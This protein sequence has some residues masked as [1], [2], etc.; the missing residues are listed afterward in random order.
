[1][2]KLYD[3]YRSSASFRV[4]IALNL[5]GLDYECIPIHLVNQGGEQ[6]AESYRKLNPQQLVPTLADGNKILTQSFAIIEYLN[7]VYPE[8]ALLPADYYT[9]SLIRSFA[10]SIVADLHPLNNLRV[11]NYLKNELHITDTQKEG[12]YQ[13]W[14]KL[15]LTALE[16]QL[17]AHQLSGQFCFGDQ[18][19]LADIC[20]VPQ[21][22]NA[23]RFN[24]DLSNYPTL[25]KID[26]H[27]QTLDAVIKA[28]PK[29]T[30]T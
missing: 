3:Y 22:Y 25:T 7:E 11:L 16:E 27:C 18:P 28:W 30:V 12:W 5:K 17:V 14:I 10:I 9:R 23:R 29:E 6:H 8:P 4:R 1:M 20:L 21:M 19:S 15:T 24:C 26:S 2:L 13:H